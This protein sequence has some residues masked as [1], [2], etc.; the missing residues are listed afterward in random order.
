M[1]LV[2]LLPPFNSLL[3]H[4]NCEFQNNIHHIDRFILHLQPDQDIM[5]VLCMRCTRDTKILRPQRCVALDGN[6]CSA[7]TEDIEL[8]NAMKELEDQIEKIH[9]KRRALRTVMNENHD[10]LIAKFPPEISSQIFIHYAPPEGCFDKNNPSTPLYLGAICQKWRQL[11]WRTPQLWSWLLVRFKP[12]PSQLLAEHLERSGNLPLTIGLSAYSRAV[13]DKTYLE[14]I[15]I[16]NRHSS[17]WHHLHCTL[18]ARHLHYLCGSLEGNILHKLVLRPLKEYH[19]LSDYSGVATFSMKCKPSPT[20]LTL[21]RY[22]LANIDIVWNNLTRALLEDIGVDECFEFMRR[23]PLLEALTLRTIIPTSGAFPIPTARIILP[24]LN[25]LSMWNISDKMVVAKILD[26]MCAPSLKHWNHL[27]PGDRS[28]ANHMVSF[29]EQSSFSLKTFKV[30]GSHN[31]YNEVHKILY[32][33]ASLEFLGLRFR[34]DDR[35]PTDEL[36]HRLCASDKF[37]PFLPHLQILDFNPQ[38]TFPWESLPQIFSSPIRR[39]LTVN[40]IQPSHA[41]IPNEAA[42]KLLELVDEGFN[43]SILRGEV[44]V[45]D[46]YREKRRLSQTTHQ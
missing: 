33:L 30:K 36:L 44:D 31:L 1:R 13:D 12:F 19:S 6:P 15:N 17:R 32:H 5:T 4:T 42:E 14:A 40:I 39:S 7:C 37:S 29:I 22:R 24:H 21:A 28:S 23:A 25:Q 2:F 46:E 9:A 43:L 18:P 38:F 16:V 10:P 27:I 11:A 45:L 8:E 35:S 41:R 34:L 26:S 20:A 3:P